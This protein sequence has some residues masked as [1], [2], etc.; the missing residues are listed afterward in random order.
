[1]ADVIAMIASGVV[2][3]ETTP[4][5]LA[6][7]AWPAVAP[8]LAGRLGAGAAAPASLVVGGVLDGGFFAPFAD[9]AFS[10]SSEAIT[11]AIRWRRKISISPLS[12]AP[13]VQMPLLPLLDAT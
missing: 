1:V 6:A 3:L 2:K 9:D 5:E 10:A 11:L 7:L 12:I 4:E 13:A 8:C